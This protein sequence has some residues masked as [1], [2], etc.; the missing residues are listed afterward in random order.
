METP[1]DNLPFAIFHLPFVIEHDSL[2]A[3][4]LDEKWQMENGK[5]RMEDL[6]RPY[7]VEVNHEHFNAT[8]IRFLD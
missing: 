8:T 1:V 2:W 3:Q 7:S 4:I 5:C 6:K